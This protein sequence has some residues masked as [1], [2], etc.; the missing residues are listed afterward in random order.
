LF[1][2]RQAFKLGQSAK[3]ALIKVTYIYAEDEVIR[4]S[5]YDAPASFC[6]HNILMYKPLVIPVATKIGLAY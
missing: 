4:K 5:N 2:W 6:R 3:H 1:N